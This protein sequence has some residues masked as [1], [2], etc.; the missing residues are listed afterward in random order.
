[1]IERLEDKLD[2]YHEEICCYLKKRQR[3]TEKLNHETDAAVEDL[4]RIFSA[5]DKV[6]N[7]EEAAA[8]IQRID[9]NIVSLK[10]FSNRIKNVNCNV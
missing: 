9:R 10:T 7:M 2:E 8:L 1:M 3:Y 6:S 5:L 4:K